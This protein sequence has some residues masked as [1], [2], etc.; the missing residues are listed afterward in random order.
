MVFEALANNQVPR[1][2][3]AWML[4]PGAAGRTRADDDGAPTR[5]M[6]SIGQGLDEQD[7]ATIGVG[8]ALEVGR[9]AARIRLQR[10]CRWQAKGVAGHT[11]SAWAAAG[12]D[13]R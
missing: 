5:A 13:G 4:Q 1:L 2:G 9:V 12:R 7:R 11:C 3:G 10:A 8:Q 6:D